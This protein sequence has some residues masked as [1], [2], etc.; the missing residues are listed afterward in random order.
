MAIPKKTENTTICRI[1]FRAMASRMLVGIACDT[2]TFRDRASPPTA[3]A[4][5]SAGIGSCM[6]LPGS[7][8]PTMTRPSDS[9]MTEA[10]MN[11]PSALPPI[12]PTVRMSSIFRDPDHEGRED[13]WRDDHLDQAKEG[14][15]QE[16]D[17]FRECGAAL[18]KCR[19]A[20]V[21][22]RNA[23]HEANHD[24]GRQAVEAHSGHFVRNA[25]P[26]QRF[27]GLSPIVQPDPEASW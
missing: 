17:A 18:G 8:S 21:T 14:A 7:N 25:D 3:A 16:G 23:G 10:K 27:D 12:R 4:A 19:M 2:S 5:S 15:G 6:T 11:Q 20:Q 26:W 1:S 13:E 22:G 9:E 24:E